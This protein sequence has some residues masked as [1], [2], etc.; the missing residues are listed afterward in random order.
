MLI[1]I[2]GRLILDWL[3]TIHGTPR[4]ILDCWAID[5]IRA[6]S[7]LIGSRPLHAWI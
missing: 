7:P 3:K 4:T 6:N 5:M 2:D 1:E